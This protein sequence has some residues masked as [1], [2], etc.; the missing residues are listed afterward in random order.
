MVDLFEN[1]MEFEGGSTRENYVEISLQKTLRACQITHNLV[2]VVVV[3]MM[4]M[5]MMMMYTWSIVSTQYAYTS[6]IRAITIDI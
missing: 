5:M 3:V 1:L 2:V 4:M 6:D